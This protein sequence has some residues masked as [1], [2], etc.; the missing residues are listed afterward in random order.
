R[1][2]LDRRADGRRLG[3][4]PP[5][6]PAGGRCPRPPVPLRRAGSGAVSSDRGHDG[7]PVVS[8]KTT[9]G[10]A[11][12]AVALG[13]PPAW[14]APRP[15]AGPDRSPADLA[16]TPD[17]RYLLTANQTADTVSL[18]DLTTGAV[19]AEVPCGRRPAALALTPDGRRVLV[20]GSHGGDL[21]VFDRDGPR[22]TRAG[23]VAL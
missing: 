15:A 23:A 9:L 1:P 13:L 4:P 16:V 3:R 11:L 7:R 10:A 17:G 19:A 2:A 12:A 20:S 8:V 21:T 6:R 14:A 5:T 22:L 18:V